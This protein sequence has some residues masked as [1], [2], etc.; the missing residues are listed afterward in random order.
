VHVTEFVFS[1]TSVG[2]IAL[3]L[4]RLLRDHQIARA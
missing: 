1:A 3:V 4:Y 2:R